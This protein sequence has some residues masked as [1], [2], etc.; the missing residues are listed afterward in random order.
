VFALFHKVVLVSAGIVV[1]YGDVARIVEYFTSPALGYEYDGKANTSE[2]MVNI[3]NGQSKPRDFDSNLNPELPPSPVSSAPARS[4]DE[5]RVLFEGSSFYAPPLECDMHKPVIECN[6]IVKDAKDD[7]D[8][9]GNGG[10]RG[11][12]YATSFFTQSVMLYHRGFLIETRNT[13]NI[14]VQSTKNLAIS[15]MMGL[16]WYGQA[17]KLPNSLYDANGTPDPAVQSIASLLYFLAIV[18]ALYGTSVISQFFI[19]KR[20]FQREQLA[21]AVAPFAFALS[22][23]T[24]P[25]LFCL[26]YALCV[27]IPMWLM[28]GFPIGGGSFIYMLITLWIGMYGAAL[29]AIMLSSVCESMQVQN[30]CVFF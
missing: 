18:V 21:G 22:A 14:R 23:F 17:A 9:S 7:M 27:Q 24:V 16:I 3:A 6:P 26:G 5:L 4:P 8:T 30:C 20:T 10:A 1:Y 12:V 29:T 15:I 11:G 19:L 25:G 2:F 13:T 28:V